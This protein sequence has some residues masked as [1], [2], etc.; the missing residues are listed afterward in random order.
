MSLIFCHLLDFVYFVFQMRSEYYSSGSLGRAGPGG[1]KVPPGTAPKPGQR[2]PGGYGTDDQNYQARDGA[3]GR[4][5]CFV[6][7]PNNHTLA[8]M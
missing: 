8:G 2:G 3:P 1:S 7:V 6:V 5:L 4:W